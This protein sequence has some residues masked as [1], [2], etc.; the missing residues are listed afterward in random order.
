MT[1]ANPASLDI[2]AAWSPDVA[3]YHAVAIGR[4]SALGLE[5]IERGGE[6]SPEAHSWDD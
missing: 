3:I 4:T 6:G 2:A 1:L 5:L